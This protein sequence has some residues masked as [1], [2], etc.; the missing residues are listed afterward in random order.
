MKKLIP[1]IL[2]I[3]LAFSYGTSKQIENYTSGIKKS[4]GMM[5]GLLWKYKNGEWIYYY[6][7]GKLKERGDYKGIFGKRTG[8]WTS[9][10]ENGMK[11][12]EVIYKRGQV[13]GAEKEW[14]KNGQI[15]EEWNL[16]NHGKK[17]GKWTS[18]YENGQM[19]AEEIYKEN[20]ENL[21]LSDEVIKIYRD[22]DG[23]WTNYY[24]RDRDGK[25]T[26]YYD[27]GQIKKEGIYKDGWKDGIWIEWH[28]NGKKKVECRHK[29]TMIDPELERSV[30]DGKFTVWT[31]DGQIKKQGNYIDGIKDWENVYIESN[32]NP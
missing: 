28:D 32:N 11:W 7:N 13:V 20:S 29:G 14:Y 4:E 12:K 22:Q 16:I 15:T 10:Y 5:K 21:I 6:P 27:N 18:Y 17:D 26:I 24:K 19:K 1:I 25:W 9:Y 30:H 8:K 23:S 31:K 2:S 3:F